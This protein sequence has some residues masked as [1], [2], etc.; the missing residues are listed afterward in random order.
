MTSLWHALKRAVVDD[1]ARSQAIRFVF[2]GLKSNAIYY[3]LYVL[4]A[5]AG[6]GPKTAVVCVFVFSLVYAFWFNKAFVFR[7]RDDLNSQFVRYVAVYLLA[8]LLNLI[9][10]EWATTTLG[11]SHFL[12]QA[13]LGV[14]I[15]V[16]I[17][18]LLKYFVFSSKSAGQTLLD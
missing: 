9:L 2:V 13:V 5:L 3:I 14:V 4:L 18:F 1:R 15:A 11:F 17:F 7:S 16:P 6:V 8:L 12:V 10:L